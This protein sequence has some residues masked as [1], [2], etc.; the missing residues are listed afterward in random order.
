MH[1]AFFSVQ[2][3]GLLM[4]VA[5]RAVAIFRIGAAP[6]LLQDCLRFFAAHLEDAKKG[7]GVKNLFR[8]AH[9]ALRANQRYL[10]ALA[11]VHDPSSSYRLLERVSEPASFFGRKV[12]GF[13]P[14]SKKDAQLFAAVIRGEHALL[15][16]RNRDLARI[17]F[18]RTP[19]NWDARRRV[20]AC[21]TRLLQRLRAHGLIA[22]IPRSRPYRVT[23]MG[24]QI[25]AASIH[26]REEEFSNII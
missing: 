18:S 26:L 23:A 11:A 17:M 25:M 7:K 22:E 3:L 4:H 14:I 13:N 9:V 2:K 6:E 12:R 24:Y 19:K 16:L 10:D 20:C 15:G 8:Y 21:V 1:A 5:S